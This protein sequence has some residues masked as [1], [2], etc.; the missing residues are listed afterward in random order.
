MIYHLIISH[1]ANY[2]Y[3]SDLS[4][5]IFKLIMFLMEKMQYLSCVERSYISSSTAI[6][7][8]LYYSERQYHSET[9]TDHKLTDIKLGLLNFSLRRFLL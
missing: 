2:E 8:W 7:C 4:Y 3:A 5:V 9:N 6:L 1:Y